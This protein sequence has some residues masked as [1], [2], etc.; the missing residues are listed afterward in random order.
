[1]TS[2]PQR[3]RSPNGLRL[4]SAVA[5]TL[6]VVLL[7]VVLVPHDPSRDDPG[8]LVLAHLVFLVVGFGAVLV[9]DW[10]A[11]LWVRGKVGVEELL[12]TTRRNAVVVWT[13]VT[14]L[15]LTG[16]LMHPNT[17][18]ALVLVKLASVAVVVLNGVH[19]ALIGDEMEV[20]QR[21]R[22]STEMPRS[23]LLRGAAVATVSQ[24]AWWTALLIGFLRARG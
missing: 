17:G 10:T 21:A 22:F 5:A 9:V 3:P 4:Q 7:V 2:E 14:G 8:L 11:L 23:V 15:V 16:A 20:W 24:V 6:L 12:A 18:S 1:M 19:A 13:G